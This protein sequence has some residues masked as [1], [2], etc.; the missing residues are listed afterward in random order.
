MIEFILKFR[1]SQLLF[2]VDS[3]KDFMPKVLELLEAQET[4]I[5]IES[6]KIQAYHQ[7]F[8]MFYD[9]TPESIPH[10]GIIK[11]SVVTEVDPSTNER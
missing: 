6:L 5:S 8:G 7:N 9:I 11:V 2:Q 1:E 3:V 10:G 4:S